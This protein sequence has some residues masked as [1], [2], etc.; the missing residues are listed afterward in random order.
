[1]ERT[2]GVVNVNY[3]M[4]I[5]VN[6]YLYNFSITFS[7]KSEYFLDLKEIAINKDRVPRP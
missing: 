1:V 5:E 6:R 7:N 4:K 2:A 3:I